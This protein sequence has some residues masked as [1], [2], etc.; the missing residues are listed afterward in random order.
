MMSERWLFVVAILVA[1]GCGREKPGTYEVRGTVAWQGAPVERGDIIFLPIDPELRAEGTKIKHGQFELRMQPG[2]R[3]VQI[4][5]SRD[6]PGQV[7]AVMH[8]PL[9]KPY[10]PA[11]YNISTTLEAQIEPHDNNR[12]K[13]D[14]PVSK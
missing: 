9:S 7:D 1:A 2:Q 13:F 3:K 11:E 10:I 4:F 14:L 12:L 6:L 8:A 5:A